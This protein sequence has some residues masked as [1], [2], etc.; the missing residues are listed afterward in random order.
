MEI[1]GVGGTLLTKVNTLIRVVEEDDILF[2]DLGPLSEAWEVDFGR[3]FMLVVIRLS[4]G[5]ETHL[6]TNISRTLI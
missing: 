6:R 4:S 3:A 1:V 2:V 5:L